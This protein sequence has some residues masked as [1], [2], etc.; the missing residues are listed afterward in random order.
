MKIIV[1]RL[2][3]TFFLVVPM[4]LNR[5]IDINE[6]S[7]NVNKCAPK[8]GD[9]KNCKKIGLMTKSIVILKNK[10]Y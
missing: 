10:K 7:I 9:S 6:N 5:K 1:P 8:N 4:L 3:S 2:N